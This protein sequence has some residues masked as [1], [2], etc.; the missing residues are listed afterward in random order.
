VLGVFGGGG[1]F[2]NSS[3]H[4][5]SLVQMEGINETHIMISIKFSM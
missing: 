4:E 5:F 1:C 3:K 2:N